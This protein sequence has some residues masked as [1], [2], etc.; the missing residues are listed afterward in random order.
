MLYHIYR[1]L[2]ARGHKTQHWQMAVLV[3]QACLQLGLRVGKGLQPGRQTFEKSSAVHV[4]SITSMQIWSSHD[5]SS[6]LI[7][8]IEMPSPNYQFFSLAPSAIT[9]TK[10]LS[11]CCSNV[12]TQL[13]TENLPSPSPSSP[14]VRLI[15]AAA[16]R[17]DHAPLFSDD[18]GEVF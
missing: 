2:T 15:H 8:K 10:C 1:S 17:H 13:R 18:A 16:M 5:I 4:H 7:I 12:P 11:P 3:V 6:Y 9:Q 14:S